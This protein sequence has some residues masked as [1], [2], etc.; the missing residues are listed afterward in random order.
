MTSRIVLL[1]VL[2]VICRPCTAEETK[3]PPVLQRLQERYEPLRLQQNKQLDAVK[4]IAT[5]MEGFNAKLEARK[6]RDAAPV[7]KKVDR[8]TSVGGELDGFN[9]DN[10]SPVGSDDGSLFNLSPI[11]ST[12]GMGG[13]GEQVPIGVNQNVRFATRWAG[14]EELKESHWAQ[15]YAFAQIVAEKLTRDDLEQIVEYPWSS[16]NWWSESSEAAGFFEFA[17]AVATEIALRETSNQKLR[18]VIATKRVSPGLGSFLVDLY[19]D[20][21]SFELLSRMANSKSDFIGR[22]EGSQRLLLGYDA[23]ADYRAKLEAKK[24]SKQSLADHEKRLL[25]SWNFADNLLPQDKPKYLDFVRRFHIAFCISPPDGNHSLS[26]FLNYGASQF[27]WKD[28][29]DQFLLHE[30][31]NALNDFYSRE[32]IRMLNAYQ[33]ARLEAMPKR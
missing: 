15:K 26:H 28:G 18:V 17:S 13:Y 19:H 5:E 4:K 2:L 6:L 8:K 10:K 23:P 33:Q 14:Y 30:A 1:F 21:R 27:R 9:R 31:E 20:E 24:A 11:P 3:Y 22:L 29:D 12:G 7:T 32:L 16:D 25:A